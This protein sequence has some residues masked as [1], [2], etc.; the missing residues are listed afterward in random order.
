M[1]LG[2]VG[3]KT[4]VSVKLKVHVM[5]WELTKKKKDSGEKNICHGMETNKKM[6][7]PKKLNGNKLKRKR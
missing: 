2:K 6:S 7:Q 4:M 3:L 5:K 1:E